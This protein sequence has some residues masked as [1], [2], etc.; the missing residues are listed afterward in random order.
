MFLSQLL[1]CFW[2]LLVIWYLYND[3]GSVFLINEFND[4][5]YELP[6]ENDKRECRNDNQ[7]NNDEKCMNLDN[8]E[9]N[10]LN[11]NN[12]STPKGAKLLAEWFE[13]VL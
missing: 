2:E 9:Y 4:V 13:N 12:K 7:C 5:F 6:D 1:I 8:S 11:S 10:N 3:S